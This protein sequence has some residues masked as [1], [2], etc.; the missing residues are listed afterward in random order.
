MGNMIDT[1]LEVLFWIS[2]PVDFTKSDA[3]QVGQVLILILSWPIVVFWSRQQPPS[4]H[5]TVIT[6]RMSVLKIFSFSPVCEEHC[7]W[8][9]ELLS[10]LLWIGKKFRGFSLTGP[11]LFKAKAAWRSSHIKHLQPV[12]LYWRAFYN[13]KHFTDEIES[14]L[15]CQ[16]W[17]M[18]ET[19]LIERV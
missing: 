14:P 3:Q 11:I 18:F 2:G 8:H 13:L 12:N 19:W 6:V 7:P 15:Q 16:R 5:I 4:Q 17:V 9:F 1:E 10:T